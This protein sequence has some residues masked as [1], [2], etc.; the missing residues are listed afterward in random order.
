[1]ASPSLLKKLKSGKRFM[2]MFGARSSPEDDR[3][4]RAA[5]LQLFAVRLGSGSMESIDFLVGVRTLPSSRPSRRVVCGTTAS[6]AHPQSVDSLRGALIV[7]SHS[8]SR[9]HRPGLQRASSVPDRR[10]QSLGSI[11]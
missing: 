2:V 7:D 9:D 1:M 5:H 6:S 11:S 4:Y 8:R 10:S 3:D